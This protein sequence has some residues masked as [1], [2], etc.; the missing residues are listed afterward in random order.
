[1]TPY[2]I[3]QN[4]NNMPAW[5]A[6]AIQ[7]GAALLG[8][9]FNNRQNK[10]NNQLAMQMAKYNTDRTIAHQKELAEYGFN[11]NLEMWQRANEYNNPKAQRSR[12]ESAGLNPALVYGQGSVTGNTSTATPQYNAPKPEYRYIPRQVQKLN[13]LGMFQDFELK[14]AQIDNTRANERS[15][16]TQTALRALGLEREQQLFPYQ[17]AAGRNKAHILNS[18]AIQEY[19]RQRMPDLNLK[20]REIQNAIANEN[21]KYLRSGFKHGQLPL[22]KMG[23]N[24]LQDFAK[25]LGISMPHTIRKF[26]NR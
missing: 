7:G 4:Q 10:K 8:G 12:L 9:L 14:Q 20:A 25:A 5:L 22:L 19:K 23:A 6:P 17:I 15:I 16:D 11:K 1:M 2:Q 3:H 21:L 24:V 26:T 18:K 13:M